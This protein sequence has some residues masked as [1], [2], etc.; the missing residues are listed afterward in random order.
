MA[1]YVPSEEQEKEHVEWM[2]VALE[3]AEEALEAD[4]VPIGCVFVRDGQVLASARNRTNEHRNATRHAELEAID[5]MLSSPD[6]I[7]TPPPD[8]PLQDV[9]LYVTVEPCIM[10]ASA[11]RQLGIK[12][13]YCGCVNDRFGGCGGVLGVNEAIPHPIWPPFPCRYGY[14]R[15]ECILILRRFY[16]TENSKAPVPRSKARRVLKEDVEDVHCDHIKMTR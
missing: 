13:V 6:I 4:E 8:L 5:S 3:L 16:L 14:L 1:I 9:V 2:R 7:P 11:L 15:E 10:C 12:G